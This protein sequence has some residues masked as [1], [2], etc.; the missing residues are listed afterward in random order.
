ME[1]LNRFKIVIPSYNNEKWVENNIASIVNQTYTNYEVLY[2]ND[3]S[4]DDTPTRVAN[5]INDYG[6]SSKWTLVSWE[7]NKQR[8]FNVNPNSKHIIDFIDDDNDILMFVDGDDWLFD[9]HV[10]QKLND[11]YNKQDCWMT[12]G[13]M[14]SYPSGKLAYPQNTP[15]SD[16][17]HANNLYRR[18]LWRA[19]HLRSFRWWLYDKIDREDLLWSKTGEYYYNAEDLAVSFFCLEMCPKERIGVLDFPTYQYNEDPEIVARGLERQQ[20]DI[21][22]PQGQEAEIRSRT[23]YKQLPDKSYQVVP[24]LAG[25]LGNMMFQ[26]A[27]V[28]GIAKNTNHKVECDFNHVGTLHTHP[29]AYQDNIFKGVDVCK[30]DKAYTPLEYASFRYKNLTLPNTD[31]KLGGY[32][33][34]YKYFDHIKDEI[35]KLF[36]PDSDAVEYIQKKYKVGEGVVSLHVRRGNYTNLS[37]Y[38]HN[39]SIE[40]Y[41]NAIDYFPGKTFLICSDD[42]E[43][44]KTHFEGDQ[45]EFIESKY[46]HIDLY[47]MA[48]C[49]HNIIANSTFSWWAA[50]LN[51]NPNK[52][53]VH[54]DKW[55]GPK[56]QQY[57]TIDMFPDEWVCM[58]ENTPQLEINLYD[59]ACRH[60]A[61]D[62]G[63]YSVV[64]GKVSKHVK[65]TRDVLDYNTGITI[66]TD[67]CL[68][69]N[70]ANSVKSKLKIG[71][72]LETREVCPE[73]YELFDQYKDDF[74]YTL[75]HDQ[76]L[77]ENYPSKTR[78]AP[79]GGCWIKDSNFQM[80]DKTKQVSMIYSDKTFMEGHKL[81]HRVAQSR[82]KDAYNIDL[83]GRGTTN[84]IKHKEEALVDYRYSIIIENSKTTNYFTEKL[85]DCLAVGTIPIYWGCTNVSEFFDPKSI[86]TFDTFDE[87]ETILQAIGQKHYDSVLD[88][89]KHNLDL[90]KN[91]NITEDWIYKNVL[92]K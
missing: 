50:Y 37:E 82:L 57:N 81:R 35:I 20:K 87:L 84:P 32:F 26:I 31:I 59:N 85:V 1:R 83:Y 41:L 38:H 18:D 62:N 71:W 2:I 17:V 44:C 63:R 67:D 47:A 48:L 52:V 33:Q 55:F 75:T 9:E 80:F 5:I 88:S 53:V 66:F 23:P 64:H 15:Y 21:E 58:S 70:S 61:R 60:L 51:Q 49:E 12:Y 90:C 91:Y 39:L 86:L 72:L 77:L 73:R 36:L 54:P 13:G 56:N 45:Y 8:G 19:S 25:G 74:E 79:F 34:S 29:K 78:F 43:W 40:Y 46:D 22:N 76:T 27:S 89:I 11:F 3:A 10:L 92:K 69:N 65:F 14:Y 16:H 30:E 68:T 42:I 24:Q 4:T 28:K 6:L 7:E